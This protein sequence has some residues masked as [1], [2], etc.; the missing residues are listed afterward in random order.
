MRK[1]IAILSAVF[2][3]FLSACG[4]GAGISSSGAESAG[5]SSSASL[6]A[7][8]AAPSSAAASSMAP[9]SGAG[10][11]LAQGGAGFVNQV[12]VTCLG[13][14]VYTLQDV[15]SGE[16]YLYEIGSMRAAMEYYDPYISVQ[17]SPSCF[18]GKDGS[19]AD[20]FGSDFYTVSTLVLRSDV[21]AATGSITGQDGLRRIFNTSA[22]ITYALLNQQLQQSPALQHNPEGGY[23]AVTPYELPSSLWVQLPGG[24]YSTTYTIEGTAVNIS[25]LQ[26]GEDY[27]ALG[28]YIG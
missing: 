18:S 27:L 24:T 9:S 23:Q 26:D 28:V 22:P 6:P 7:S 12:F 10:S 13:Q 8:S 3:L 19:V 21:D 2:L 1:A 4:G 15:L 14:P 20:P 25:F 5:A 11:S 16:Y 17:F